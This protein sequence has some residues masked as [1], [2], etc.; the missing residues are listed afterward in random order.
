MGRK[1]ER[2]IH[3]NNV[4][5]A[6]IT[7]RAFVPSARSADR[8]RRQVARSLSRKLL[9]RPS[10]PKRRVSTIRSPYRWEAVVRGGSEGRERDEIEVAA[11]IPRREQIG[12]HLS[13]A[14]DYVIEA[15]QVLGHLA[16][17]RQV[18]G[19]QALNLLHA[20][21]VSGHW[22]G[23]SSAKPQCRT[24]GALRRTRGTARGP[25]RCHRWRRLV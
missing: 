11:R 10:Q 22:S 15:L 25:T 1:A 2:R 14:G 20:G 17:E 8:I 6:T 13:G 21:R 3:A 19:V 12:H 23:V 16:R 7:Q 5:A 9:H 18:L 24:C 4:T